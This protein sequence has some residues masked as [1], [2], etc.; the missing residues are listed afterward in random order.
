VSLAD[1]ALAARRRLRGSGLR[2]GTR[3]CYRGR[4]T[5]RRRRLVLGVALALLSGC[6]TTPGSGKA[7][8]LTPAERDSLS[9]TLEPLL[10]AASLWRGPGEGC[11]AAYGVVDGEPIVVLITPHAPCRV[12]LALTEGAMAKLDRETLGV[13]LA[14][15]LAHLQ[16][17]HPEARQKREEER[18]AT[19]KQV[20]TATGVAK[21]GV[22][23]IP[24]V[25]GFI[26]KGIS[27]AQK[28]T[29]AAMQ[30]HG[31]P[32]LP[33]EEREADAA[34]VKYLDAAGSAGCAL[35]ALLHER[36]RSSTEDAWTLWVH[37]HPVTDERVAALA[38]PCPKTAGS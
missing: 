17:G 15:D 25:G 4:V 11:A 9:R 16:L 1:G 20:K 27:T 21:K 35:A 3:D 37:Q 14:H 2:A 22:G 26:G 19:E 13:V 24:V 7:R 33:E 6:A 23:F 12:K 30:A 34:T 8:E 29:F 36:L 10:S 31:N 32:Y 38:E 28:A 18:K 5:I